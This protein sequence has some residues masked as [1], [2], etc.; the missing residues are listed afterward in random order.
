[1]LFV[2]GIVVAIALPNYANQ[3][4]RTQV[5][6]G[7]VLGAP[8]K[9][10]MVAY[11]QR[12]HVLP[13]DN[14]AAGLAH[15][16]SISGNYVSAV[17]VAGGAVTVSFDTPDAR[18]DIRHQALVYFPIIDGDHLRWDCNAYSTVPARDLPRSCRK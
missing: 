9:A 8:A 15:S 7:E 1:M 5:A 4:I 17:N 12:H 2:L 13:A 10:A 11:Y 14:V 16:T 6:E 18:G 3:A